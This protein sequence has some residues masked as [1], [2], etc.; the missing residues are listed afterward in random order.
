ML[1]LNAM[2]VSTSQHNVYNVLTTWNV[3]FTWYDSS[4]CHLCAATSK[5][6]SNATFII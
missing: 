4:H 1:L 6:L 2:H 3:L 5:Y